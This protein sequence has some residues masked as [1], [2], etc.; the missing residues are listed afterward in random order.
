MDGDANLLA[1]PKIRVRDH[2]KAKVMIGDKVPVVTTTSTPNGFVAENIQYLDVGLK[3]EVEPTIHL[4]DDVGLKIGLE[5]SS[6]V[7][8]IKTNNGSSAYQIGTRNFN[9]VLRLKDGETQLLAGLINDEA[10]SAANGIPLLGDLPV[11]GRLF[12]S[13]NDNRQKTEIVMSITPHLI[14]NIR[15]KDPMS[16]S[17]WSGTEASLRSKPLQLRSFDAVAN[18]NPNVVAAGTLPANGIP[19]QAV[20]NPNAAADNGRLKLQWKGP[21]QVKV[22]QPFTLELNLDSQDALRAA[23]LQLQFDPAAFEIVTVKEGDYFSKNGKSSF[24]HVI[25]KPSGRI[26]VG[27]ASADGAGAQG[28]GQLLSVELRPLTVNAEAQ[29]S[30]V[31]MTPIGS[32]QALTRP[33]TPVVYKVAVAQ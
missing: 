27:A 32:G 2:E 23:P 8:S 26:S 30:V 17:F 20:P 9:S 11:L 25:D 22:G 15:R 18:G 14:R 13:Q 28:K 16:E 10:R 33:T 29:V 5:V 1:N 19:A 12:S 6:L 24:N 31:G 3:L 4:H 21:D 7:S